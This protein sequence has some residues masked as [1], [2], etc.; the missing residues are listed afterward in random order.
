ME[1]SARNSFACT[2]PQAFA[3]LT[4]AEFLRQ[5]ALASNPIS[6]SVSVDGNH[7]KTE[8]TLA[9]VPPA[10]AFTG[11][12][13]NLIDQLAWDEP[14]TDDGGSQ[15]TGAASVELAG[16]PLSL[17]GTVCLRPEGP[18]CV[19]EYSG[20]LT[21]SIPVLGKKLE[22]I[23]APLLLKGIDFQQQVADTWLA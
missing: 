20:E 4:D 9:S 23:A 1:F 5:V 15:R 19:L 16:L 17:E 12:E 6:C 21:V 7:T 2:V 14:S 10:S 11:P 22:T 3:M 13:V 18:G 8:R